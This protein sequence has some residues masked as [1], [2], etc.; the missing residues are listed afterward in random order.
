[1]AT[2][3][4]RLEVVFE[5]N[6]T[7]RIVENV[8]CKALR[9]L[10]NKQSKKKKETWCDTLFP[11]QPLFQF[12]P[13]VVLVLSPDGET[14][15][16]DGDLILNRFPFGDRMLTMEELVSELGMPNVMPTESGMQKY[17]FQGKVWSPKVKFDVEFTF[18]LPMPLS[19]EALATTKIILSKWIGLRP[20]PR[21]QKQMHT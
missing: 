3:A 7:D 12:E 17:C 6:F 14:E 10:S 1:M 8:L 4:K 2:L 18:P 15:E 16:V 20:I 5:T 21:K 19:R 13:N 11:G 9:A